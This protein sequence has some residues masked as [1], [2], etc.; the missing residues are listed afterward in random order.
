[1][2][3]VAGNEGEIPTTLAGGLWGAYPMTAAHFYKELASMAPN[4][5]NLWGLVASMAPNPM[6]L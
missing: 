3:A 6:N 5:M 2:Y 4:P 1:M